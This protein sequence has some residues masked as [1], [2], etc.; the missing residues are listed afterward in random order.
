VTLTREDPELE[1]P[2]D[3]ID[4][5]VGYFRAA[6]KPREA[7]LVGT[8]YEKLGIRED[9]FQPLPYAGER[10]I[11]VVLEKLAEQHGFTPIAQGELI[12][13][14]EQGPTRITLEPGGALELG[15]SPLASVHQSCLEFGD[16]LAVL[17]E[18]SAGLGIA[19]LALGAHPFARLDEAPR[20]PSE[21]HDIMREVLARTGSL[22]LHMMH[23]TAGV[24]TNLDFSSER[25]VGRKMRVAA[26]VSPI[27]TACYANSAL[28]EGR[29]NGFA[30]FRAEIW[31]H[32]DPARCGFPSVIFEAAWLEGNAYRLYTEW[33]LDVPM[34]FIRRDGRHVRMGGITFRE[35]LDRRRPEFRPTLADWSLHLTALFPEVRLKRVI[36]IRD[37][38]A[39]P[40]GLVCSLPALWKGLL[41]DEQAMT[42]ALA[43]VGHWT[44][45][46]VE[47]LW[48]EVARSGLEARTTDGPLAKTAR[49]IVAIARRGLD[50]IALRNRS[51]RSEAV[52]LDP[53]QDV[54]ERGTS[55]GR[56]V[57]RRWEGDFGRDPRRLLE[58]ARY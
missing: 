5:L 9:T 37:A 1:R 2:I 14:L 21:R 58:Y 17:K 15:G 20:M 29:P 55:P 16:H 38:D 46:D 34:F 27:A 30:S 45:T 7:W 36:E 40:A 56:E 18:V 6:E 19:W 25:D 47:R 43:R 39:V 11:R 4:D 3:G 48:A 50:R 53:L 42:E 26:L 12:V 57:V 41:Y 33:A 31:R 24:Q 32:T 22:G 52:Y 8:E 23:L 35:Y 10:G 49:E 54:V 51:G 13:G 28:S 44:R